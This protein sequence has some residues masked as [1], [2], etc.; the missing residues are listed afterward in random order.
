MLLLLAALIALAHASAVPVESSGADV[1]RDQT[2]QR[3][4]IEPSDLLSNFSQPG[5]HVQEEQQQTNAINRSPQRAQK[6]TVQVL[7]LEV[8]RNRLGLR[9]NETENRRNKTLAYSIVN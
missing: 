7:T 4:Y 9:A 2:D 8:L 1:G 5:A 6:Q 3:H